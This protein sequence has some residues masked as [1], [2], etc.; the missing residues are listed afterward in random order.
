MYFFPK[1]FTGQKQRI[2]IARALIRR[3]RILLLDEATSALDSES[4]AVVQKAIDQIMEDQMQTVIIVAHR[5]STIR[6]ADMIVVVQEGRVVEKG[7]HS[8]L[9]KKRSYF[10][11]L[12]EQHESSKSSR[13]PSFG[14]ASSISLT[15][16]CSSSTEGELSDENCL[17]AFQDVHF[18]YPSRPS[19]KI[20]RG[21]DL[22]IHQGETLALVGPSGQGKSTIIQLLEGFYRP[23]SGTI[24]YKDTD[25]SEINVDWLRKQFGLVSQEPNLF[26][27][28]IAENIRF[29]IPDA[30]QEDIEE[31]A[32]AA[33]AHDFIMSFPDKYD[34][35][36][37]ATGSTK[38]SGGEKQRIAIARALLRKPKVLL[39]DEA[40]SALDSTSE[41]VVQAA[42]DK[43]MADETQTTIVIAHRLSTIRN[44]DRIAVVDRGRVCELGTH[45][46]LMML[47]GGIYRKLQ[48]LQNM[49]T[50]ERKRMITTQRRKSLTDSKV[51]KK[52]EKGAEVC[53]VDDEVV[54]EKGSDSVIRKAREFS[55][56][57]WGLF[58]I[59]SFGAILAGLMFPGWGFTFAYMIEL[60]YRPIPVCDADF[61]TCQEH[62]DRAADEMQALSFNIAFGLVGVILSAVVGN[63]LVWYGFGTAAERL[64]K[65][66]R[67]A[68][69]KNLLRQEVAWFDTQ[70]I[71]DLASRVA[72]D[73][74]L[75]NTFCGSPIRMAIMNISSVLVGIATSFFFM[76]PFAVVAVFTLPFLVFAARARV[77]MFLGEDQGTYKQ[78]SEKSSGGIVIETLSNIRT[79]ASL[80]IEGACSK[81]YLE[82]LEVEE[83]SSISINMRKASMG[84]GQLVR[85]WCIA[86]FFWWGGYILHHQPGVYS[87][88]DFLIS[89]F[90]LMFSITGMAMSMQGVSDPKVAKEA[91]KR[92]FELIERRSAIDPLSKDG[93][94]DL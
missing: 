87:L 20:F 76:W 6:N 32:K 10:F 84:L 19:A 22:R 27:A 67:D 78:E 53:S 14:A 89:M 45:N 82:T 13:R 72:D 91:A 57:D 54:A 52:G 26:H 70:S 43:I 93:R 5:L 36:V 40:T 39:L 25:I 59:G 34:T 37:G 51:E 63:S 83:P 18:H 94:M 80:G 68:L 49:G 50:D 17:L 4:E 21:L 12:A 7:T 8:E 3:P 46:E 62:W 33:N 85:V 30:T 86:L 24:S 56:G 90:S 61:R 81:R 2:A 29:G 35:I 58:L 88:R 64:N 1:L 42:L 79:V 66:V 65:K 23:T 11:H 74:A 28:S 75:L 71:D 31:A 15:D 69:F 77:K 73:T 48:S 92:V 38:V 41:R 55:K 47:E 16:D 44:A 60:L 9:M